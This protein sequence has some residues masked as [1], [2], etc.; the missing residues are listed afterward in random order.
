MTEQEFIEKMEDEGTE[1][2]FTDYG[3]SED[4][5]DDELRGSDFWLAVRD[6]RLAFENASIM[7]SRIYSSAT[8]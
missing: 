7:V 1:Y 2:A 6:V 4:S 3:L 8:C 5:L